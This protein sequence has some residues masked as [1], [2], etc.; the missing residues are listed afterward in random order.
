MITT[1]IALAMSA[2]ATAQDRGQLLIDRNRIDRP[3]LPTAEPAPD[4][5]VA[6]PVIEG[7]APDTTITGIAFE[8]TEAPGNVAEAAKPFLGRKASGATLAELAA[9]LSGAYAGADVALYT[10]SIPTQD[11]VGGV[12]RVRIIEGRIATVEVPGKN[13]LLRARLAPLTRET[14]LSR[15]TFERQQTLAREI[16]GLTFDTAL[17]DP[18]GTGALT[19]AV[20]P[21]QR[22]TRFGLG[23]SN[24]GLDLLGPGQFD[25]K[26]E[27]FGALTDGDRFELSGA[28]SPDFDQL[29][30]AA[31]NYVTPIGAGGLSFGVN[32]AFLETRP[33]SV[34]LTGRAKAAGATISYALVRGFQRSGDISLGI[35]GL[36]SD[37]AVL[38]NVFSQERTRAVRGSASLSAAKPRRQFAVAG[39]LSKGIDGLGARAGDL[40][41]E[42]GFIKATLGASFAQAIGQRAAVRLNASG[43][44]SGDRLPAAER[45]SVGGEA[46]GRAFDTAIL[47]GD[48]GVGGLAELGWRPIKGG[49]FATSEIYAFGD[50]AAVALV[51]RGGFAR[52]DYSLAS[53]GIGVRARY[54]TKAE[55]GLEGA[56]VI[57]DP[58]AGYPD[59]WRVS[60][61]W[62]LSL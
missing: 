30:Y 23:F 8:G 54:L 25:A 2:Q 50:A 49:R 38:G 41:A 36:N 60:V 15:R 6:A 52:Q 33:D 11:F 27:L 28:A 45:Y 21:K 26:A 58:Y 5:P 55:V 59:D 42:P 47:T 18:D 53:A 48:R 43:Q 3:P 39:A 7:G 51:D 61:S 10:V 46:V 16:P 44:Y 40:F 19:L 34:P 13:H 62:R 1:L 56:R 35:D 57:D 37:N 9:A 17:T 24:R 31:A 32:A 29:R 22:R 14:P 20:T 4:T 12:V